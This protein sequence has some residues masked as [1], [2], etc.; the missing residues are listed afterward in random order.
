MSRTRRSSYPRTGKDIGR[1]EYPEEFRIKQRRG[2][3]KNSF[4]DDETQMEIWE[5]KLK[6]SF[7]KERS[8]KERQKAKQKLK[9]Y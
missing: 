9:N 7:K 5:P 6:K 2:H 3:V 1:G 4:F 8:K